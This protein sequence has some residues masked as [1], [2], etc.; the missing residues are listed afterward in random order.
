[1]R[2]TQSGSKKPNPPWRTVPVPVSVPVVVEAAVMACGGAQPP[3]AAVA[4]LLCL[5]CDV[6]RYGFLWAYSHV[7][8][9]C[10]DVMLI[11]NST[12]AMRQLKNPSETG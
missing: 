10:H 2:A 5:R 4:R 9:A 1:M 11:W 8:G 6:I 7:H 12:Q 3:P